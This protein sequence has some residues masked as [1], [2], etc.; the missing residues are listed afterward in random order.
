[1]KNISLIGKVS[2]KAW[3]RRDIQDNA[4][5]RHVDGTCEHESENQPFAVCR[6]AGWTQVIL[7]VSGADNFLFLKKGQLCAAGH[8]AAERGAASRALISFAAIKNGERLSA[9]TLGKRNNRHRCLV[10]LMAPSH[11]GWLW[12]G[13]MVNL[14]LA[15]EHLKSLTVL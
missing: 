5:C 7:A 1:M 10:P 8:E 15:Q 13:G 12:T 4:G 2:A 11:S 14:G 6:P 9:Q 3:F